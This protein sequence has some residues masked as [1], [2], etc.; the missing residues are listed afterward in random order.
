MARRKAQGELAGAVAKHSR[1]LAA[2]AAQL[3]ERATSERDDYFAQRTS[4]NSQLQ[5]VKQ[6]VS[7]ARQQLDRLS[8]PR[9]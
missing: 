2:R 5:Q 9:P 6:H 3:L 8:K 1:D 7:A 4:L